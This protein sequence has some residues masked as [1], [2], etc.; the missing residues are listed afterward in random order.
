MA[1]PASPT[2]PV[3]ASTLRA[4]PSRL[5]EVF[6][7]L[8]TQVAGGVLPSAA[9]AIGDADGEIA[10][11]TF[12]PPD[13]PFTR[14]SAFFLASVTK[15]IFATAFMQLVE[16]GRIDLHQPVADVLPEFNAGGD[17]QKARVTWWHVLTHTSGVPDVSPDVIR[18]SRPSAARMTQM[19]VAAPLDFE[20]GTRYVYCTATFYLMARAIERVSGL[21]YTR[22]LQ[23]SVL[24]PLGMEATF[25]ARKSRRPIVAVQGVG[26]ENRLVRFLIVRYLAATALPGGGLFGTLD[27]LLKFGAAMIRPA[28]GRVPISRT[29][30]DLMA[31]DHLG[32]RVRGSWDDEDSVV[33]FG[34]SWGKPTLMRNMPGSSSTVSHGGATG[35][36]IWIDPETELVFV[37]FTNQWGQDR[38]PEVEAIRGIYSAMGWPTAA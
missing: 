29:T 5:N 31:Q 4:D 36:R 8:R 32:G 14:E 17:P 34:L 16:D 25:D 20:P 30:F 22:Y 33:H 19:T 9:I 10:S 12:A 35:T 26:V 28:D 27:D 13:K 24:D 18:R 6:D 2:S 11:M 15:P 1:I 21:R 3:H 23:E 37:F 7:R 38:G